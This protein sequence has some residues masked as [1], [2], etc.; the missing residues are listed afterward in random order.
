MRLPPPDARREPTRLAAS[1]EL[2]ADGRVSL[3]GT[4]Y[5]AGSALTMDRAIANTVRFTGLPIDAVI[6]MASTIPADYLGLATG[7]TVTADWDQDTAAL[8]VRRVMV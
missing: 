1:A 7:G 3:P 8:H 2:S 4:P 5:L 6:K